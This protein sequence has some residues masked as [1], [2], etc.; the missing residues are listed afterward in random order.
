MLA[1]A[2]SYIAFIMLRLRY[3]SCTS[4]NSK[5]IKYLNV[6]PESL[7]LVQ[8]R[9]GHSLELIGISNDFLNRTQKA[10]CLREIIDK[11]D[12]MKLKDFGTTKEMVTRLK[13]QPTEWSAIHLTRD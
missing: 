10:Q 3:I 4:I 8:E 7:K 5:W 13:R 6:R 2:L 9:V 12:C 11:W 1:V